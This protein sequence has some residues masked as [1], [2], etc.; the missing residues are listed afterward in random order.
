MI[1]VDVHTVLLPHLHHN[2]KLLRVGEEVM[3]RATA[4][5]FPS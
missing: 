4:S 5:G 2:P 3:G 1:A